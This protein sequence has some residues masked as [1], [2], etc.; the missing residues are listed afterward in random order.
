M[1]AAPASG[2]A[3][4]AVNNDSTSS[5]RAPAELLLPGTVGS[6]DSSG[7][8]GYAHGA[9]DSLDGSGCY[10]AEQIRVKF[11]RFENSLFS[12]SGQDHGDSI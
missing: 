10:A 1:P 12:G 3:A 9:A 8:G 2:T 11:S 4:P 7:C 5:S 6:R